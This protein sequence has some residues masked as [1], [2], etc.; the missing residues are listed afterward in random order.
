[1]T[2]KL[3]SYG[4][5][6]ERAAPRSQSKVISHFA[7]VTLPTATATAVYTPL[8]DAV[9]ALVSDMINRFVAHGLDAEGDVLVRRYFAVV[10][11]LRG[12]VS[13]AT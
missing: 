10:D 7:W 6:D 8:D 13:Q 2:E 12:A 4:S 9:K 1:M 11:R 5:P 3:G